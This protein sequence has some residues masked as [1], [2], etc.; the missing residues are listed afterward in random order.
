MKIIKVTATGK[1]KEVMT[2]PPSRR[3]HWQD[4]LW[5]YAEFHDFKCDISPDKS[6]VTIDCGKGD[7]RTWLFRDR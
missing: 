5:C 2:I 4:I 1:E 7:V 3:E 6:K